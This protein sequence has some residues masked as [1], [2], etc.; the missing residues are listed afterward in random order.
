MLDQG[1]PVKMYERRNS[2]TTQKAGA[3]RRAGSFVFR[4]VD[5]KRTA[6]IPVYKLR[7]A[8]SNITIRTLTVKEIPP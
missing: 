3:M 7:K 2:R 6:K 5:E 8:Q 1:K 4:M